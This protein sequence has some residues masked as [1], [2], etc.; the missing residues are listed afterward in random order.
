MFSW[1][2]PKLSISGHCGECGASISADVYEGEELRDVL[3]ERF[4]C[5]C[6]DKEYGEKIFQENNFKLRV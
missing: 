4:K 2:I 5:W 1:Q 3:R 6:C